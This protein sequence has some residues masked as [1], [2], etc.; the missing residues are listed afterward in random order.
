MIDKIYGLILRKSLK[1]EPNMIYTLKSQAEKDTSIE[2]YELD[3]F[4][5][6]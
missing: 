2:P 3:E 6:K 4:R 1:S 5:A